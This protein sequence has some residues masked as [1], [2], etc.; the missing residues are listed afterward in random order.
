MIKDIKIESFKSIASENLEFKKLT[1]LTG[2][3]GSGKSSVIQSLRMIFNSSSE[4]SPY[5][6]GFGGFQELLSR[7]AKGSS[8]KISFLL[9]F[10]D[11]SSASLKL[12]K[13]DISFN[14]AIPDFRFDYICADR[15]GPAVVL[16]TLNDRDIKVGIKGEYSADYFLKFERL[17]INK[18]LIYENSSSLL[19]GEQLQHWISEISPGVKL[20]FSSDTK[21]D[22]SHFEIDGYRATNA[23]FGVSYSLPIVLATLVLSANDDSDLDDANAQAWYD[24]Y[25]G[26][27][28]VLIVENPEAHLHPKGQTAMGELLALAASCGIQILVETH[29]DHFIDGVRIAAKKY[30]SVNAKDILI[31]FFKKSEKGITTSEEIKILPSGSLDKWPAGFFDQMDLNLKRLTSR[32]N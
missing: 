4:N 20:G 25:K 6:N 16:P 30:E 3:N 21:H 10:K 28:T 11:D 19:L 1:I 15:F 22:S 24:K 14:G 9:N 5:I 12:T 27:N 13:R 2:L 29:S 18:K 23:G 31:H 26:K 8:D 7:F 32:R 17:K